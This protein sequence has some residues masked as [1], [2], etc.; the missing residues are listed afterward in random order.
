MLFDEA[1]ELAVNYYKD[2]LTKA[3]ETADLFIFYSGNPSL[4][5]VGGFGISINKKTKEIKKF[6]L[7]NKAN[8]ELLKEAKEKQIPSK[9]KKRGE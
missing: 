4:V 7:P 6:I 1:C 5:C 2:N 9:F 3:L 8:F